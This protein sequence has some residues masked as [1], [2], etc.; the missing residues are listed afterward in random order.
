[1]LYKLFVSALTLPLLCCHLNAENRMVWQYSVEKQPSADLGNGYYRNPVLVGT[2]GDVTIC[3]KGHDYYMTHTNFGTPKMLIWHSTDLVNWEPLDFAL[4]EYIGTVWAIDLDYYDGYFYLYMPVITNIDKG[5][6]HFT[7]MVMKAENPAG[8]W[9][10]PYDLGFGRIDPG[11]VVDTNGQRYVYVDKGYLHKVSND[12]LKADTTAYKVYDGWP[13]PEDWVFECHCL[14]SPKFTWYNNYCYMI[15][16]QGGTSGPSTAHMVTVA[17]SKS[18]AGPWENSPV[19]PLVRTK[20]RS[21]RWWR[22]GHGDFAVDADSNWWMMYTGY[23]NGYESF[24][25]INLL[26][27]IDWNAD[28]WPIIKNDYQSTDMIP[29]PAGKSVKHGLSLSDNFEGTKLGLQWHWLEHYTPVNRYKLKNGS[30]IMQAS[31]YNLKSASKILVSPTNYAYE[32]V[33]KLVIDNG[34]EAGLIMCD[35]ASENAVGAGIRKGQVFSTWRSKQHVAVPFR[36][37]EVY[38]KVR[39]DNYDI[40]TFYSLDG[41]LW[42]KFYKSG[43]STG[44]TVGGIYCFGEGKAEFEFFKYQGL[45]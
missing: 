37:T 14:E 3:Q 12:G 39:N 18:A 20:T 28:G 27:P 16:A 42:R 29:K 2:Q 40:S 24:R 25:K 30:M 45:D 9:E 36:K 8:P 26:L 7:N 32:F 13:I 19:N 6:R 34:V 23:E 1:M 4:K 43:R 15:S 11:H 35:R 44:T 22:Q 31:G 33:T 17:R 41:V 21:E 10:G 5:G 38:L